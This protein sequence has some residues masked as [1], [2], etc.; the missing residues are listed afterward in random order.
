M[1]LLATLLTTTML[2]GAG[3]PGPNAQMVEGTTE[4]RLLGPLAKI[5]DPE[6]H[7]SGFFVAPNLVVTAR[8][9]IEDLTKTGAYV[10]D[11]KGNKH[12]IMEVQ[13][14][15]D[16]DVG[17]IVVDN[18]DPGQIVAKIKCEMPKRFATLVATGAPLSANNVTSPQMVVGFDDERDLDDVTSLVLSG[19]VD[20]G[21]SGGPIYNLDA[22]VV[23][24]VSNF[25]VYGE[26]SEHRSNFNR[27]VPLVT[28]PEL[29]PPPGTQPVEEPPVPSE[30]PKPGEED[31]A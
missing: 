9:V 28:I 11:I 15:Y 31:P 24:V 4:A 5:K 23:A 1:K 3:V 25:Q 7:G 13:A 30:Q 16:G 10:Y 29:C 22:E 8:H 14:A 19:D 18:P 27:A 6:G 12:R 26:N 2:M 20:P 21:M 17:I